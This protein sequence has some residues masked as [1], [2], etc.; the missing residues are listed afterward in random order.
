M[1]SASSSNSPG[2]V[3]AEDPRDSFRLELETLRER[4]QHR[5]L[6][7]VSR[8][9]GGTV[10]LEGRR[11]LDLSSN[12]YLGL[13]GDLGPLAGSLPGRGGHSRSTER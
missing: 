8:R 5:A 1:T 12:D 10:V 11:F 3:M 9:P 13:A 4:R 7:T 2:S 6:R